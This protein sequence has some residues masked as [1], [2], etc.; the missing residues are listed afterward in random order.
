MS[1][2]SQQLRQ[3]EEEEDP[4]TLVTSRRKTKFNRKPTLSARSLVDSLDGVT[5]DE[6]SILK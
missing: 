4:F 2:D 5:I 1:N 6:D 3:A